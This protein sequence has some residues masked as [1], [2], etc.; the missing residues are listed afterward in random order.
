MIRFSSLLLVILCSVIITFAQESLGCRFFGL[1]IHPRGEPENAAIMPLRLDKQAVFVQNLGGILSYEHPL[2]RDILLYKGT[3]GLY[4]DCALQLG[5]FV[6]LGIRGRLFASGKHRLY[7]GIGPTIIFR[8]NWL[9]IEGYR[10]QQLFHGNRDDTFQYL[11]LWHGG[12][13]DYRYRLSPKWD[14]GITFVPGYPDL[15][16]LSVGCNLLL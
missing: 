8:K 10:D 12:E 7:G 13:F 4:A 5:G 14:L 2:Y 16:S 6:H 9:A 3:I 1:S 15:I 11:F